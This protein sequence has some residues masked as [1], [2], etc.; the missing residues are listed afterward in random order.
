MKYGPEDSIVVNRR[1]IPLYELPDG[2]KTHFSPRSAVHTPLQ[3]HGEGL[4]KHKWEEADIVEI[5]T[6]AEYNRSGRKNGWL[7]K[8]QQKALAKS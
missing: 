6:R 3:I 1:G 7:K 2:T 5:C 4:I 8:R